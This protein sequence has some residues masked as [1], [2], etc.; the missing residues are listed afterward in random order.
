MINAKIIA[1][2]LV[3]N[4]Y[5]IGVDEIEGGHRLR[6]TRG[7]EEKTIDIMDGLQGPQGET[8]L[9]GPRGETGPQGP[10][11]ETGLQGPR[12]ETGPQGPQGDTGEAGYTPVKGVDYFTDAEKGEMIQAVLDALPAAEGAN[13]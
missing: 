10:R 8:G 5:A 12:G 1:G 9:Q 6:I 11:G 13:Y 3:L 4:D 7:N 2:K